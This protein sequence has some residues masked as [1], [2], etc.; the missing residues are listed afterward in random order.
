MNKL[1]TLAIVFSCLAGWQARAQVTGTF[2]NKS[3]AEISVFWVDDQG[4]N[5]PYHDLKIAPGKSAAFSTYAGSKWRL[6]QGQKLVGEYVGTDA[7]GQVFTVQPTT[8]PPPP[9]PPGPNTP[10]PPPVPAAQPASLSFENKS[11]FVLQV[12]ELDLEAKSFVFRAGIAPQAKADLS[13]KA[14]SLWSVAIENVRVMNVTA[15]AGAN[16]VPVEVPYREI[17]VINQR[18]NDLGVYSIVNTSDRHRELAVLRP[19]ES[20]TYTEWVG[21]ALTF[22]EGETVV[23]SARVT[24]LD[25]QEYELIDDEV[26]ADLPIATAPVAVE[27]VNQTGSLLVVSLVLP[28]G[29]EL[30]PVDILQGKATKKIEAYPF[31]SWLVSTT[32]GD[33]VGEYDI[34]LSPIQQIVITPA[35]LP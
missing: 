35:D 29:E 23:G 2:E 28:D 10:P 16:A 4:N 25:S 9:P 30:I 33:V 13:G 31:S 15:K 17:K 26:A 32:E 8:A 1:L 6:Y 14:G 24:T 21:A 18:A 22:R 27:V 3:T 34:E 11:P 5:Q 20:G 7:A 19:G 12:F